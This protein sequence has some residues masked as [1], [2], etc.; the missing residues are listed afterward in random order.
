MNTKNLDTFITLTKYSSIN[1][2]ADALFI[3]SPALQQQINRLESEI[4]F[5]LFERGSAGIRLTPAGETFLDGVIKLRSDTESLLARCRE[6]D[7]LN[8]CLR[9]GA[10][11]GLQP[12]LFP[13]VSGPFYQKYPHVVQKPVMESEEQ[14]FS[15]LDRGALDVIEYFDCPR[16]HAAGRNFE[17]LFWEGRD[18]MMSPTHPLA[19]RETLTLDDLAG[20]HIIVY[21]FDRLPGLREYVE[22]WYPDIRISEDP[23]VMDLYTVVR[24]FE[25]GHIGLVPP[26]VGSQFHPLRTIPLKMDMSWPI[27]L[28]YREPRS[29]VVSQFIEVAKQV[30]SKHAQAC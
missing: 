5:K 13:R 18:C 4:G 11:L 8:K 17:P 15:D 7:S 27:G 22:K 12:D 29:A 23:R 10:I 1:A 16:A 6:T 24:S 25:D 14:L 28:V 3:S 9:V 26:H 30:F 21:R 19:S 20:Q 2:A